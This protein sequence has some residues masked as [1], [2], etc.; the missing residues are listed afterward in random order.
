MEDPMRCKAAWKIGDSIDTGKK[1][2]QY[3]SCECTVNCK[4]QSSKFGMPFQEIVCNPMSSNTIA[5]I[6]IYP[7]FQMRE[8]IM[9]RN[10]GHCKFEVVVP[11][12]ETT[13]PKGKER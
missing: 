9:K 12:G 2:H 7:L 6:I 3:L 8:H 10:T 11:I 5:Y 1:H 4:C 13:A